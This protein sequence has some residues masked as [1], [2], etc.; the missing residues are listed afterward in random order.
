MKKIIFVS[1]MIALV[2]FGCV[3]QPTANVTQNNSSV[4]NSSTTPIMIIST[5]TNHSELKMNDTATVDYTLWVDGKVLDTSNA[6]LGNASGL[7]KT[8][9]G[10][11]TYKLDLN[12]SLIKGFVLNT[13]GMKVNET[14]RFLVEPELGYGVWNPNKIVTT[15]RYYNK[16]LE[17]VVPRSY[18]TQQGITNL[19]NGTSF[20]TAYG[21]V[22][23]SNLDSENVTLFYV[24]RAG[25]E[26]NANGIPQ[27][28]VSL[29]NLTATIEF[30]LNLN[31][32]YYVPNPQ[33]G[34]VEALKVTNKTNTTITVDTNHELAGKQLEFEV[35]VLRI[36]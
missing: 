1:L 15:E 26:F 7:R 19:T 18:F 17:E 9:Y 28:V 32:T 29:N 16:T 12:G 33:T 10:P 22:F 11:I 27:K 35:K 31:E 8:N 30:M 25:Q 4:S 14:K 13:L 34:A 23:I 5:T 20:S 21:S 24:L 3:N 6:T 2:F 36:N